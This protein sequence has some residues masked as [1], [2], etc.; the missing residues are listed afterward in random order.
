MSRNEGGTS[1]IVASVEFCCSA[2]LCS[3]EGRS[4]WPRRQRRAVECDGADVAPCQ[5]QGRCWNLQSFRLFAFWGESISVVSAT[6]KRTASATA[7]AAPLFRRLQGSPSVP[8]GQIEGLSALVRVLL[9]LLL[10]SGAPAA[11]SVRRGRGGG[12]R[13]EFRWPRWDIGLGLGWGRRAP[14]V[15]VGAE[16]DDGALLLLTLLQ[17]TEEF[18]LL[19]QGADAE[20]RVETRVE[21]VIPTLLCPQGCQGPPL[22]LLLSFLLLLLHFQLLGLLFLK[23]K[24][25]RSQAHLHRLRVHLKDLREGHKLINKLLANHLLDDVLQNMQTQFTAIRSLWKTNQ[26]HT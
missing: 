10:S 11:L 23:G 5:Q 3:E 19:L 18:G 25:S 22:G 7:A 20:W 2:H 13:G 24:P 26:V 9:L 17:G 21:V 1:V 15:G 6:V 16:A 8:G 4:E 12:M 14:L